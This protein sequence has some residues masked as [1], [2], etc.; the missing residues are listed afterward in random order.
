MRSVFVES[1]QNE[2]HRVPQHDVRVF[3]VRVARHKVDV[4]L[5]NIRYCALHDPILRVDFRLLVNISLSA[6][7]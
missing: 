1:R 7:R 4:C 2:F 5:Q 3:G 6:A